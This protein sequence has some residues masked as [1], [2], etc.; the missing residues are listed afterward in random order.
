MGGDAHLAAQVHK[1]DDVESLKNLWECVQW[2]KQSTGCENLWEYVQWNEQ[3]TG[4]DD[5]LAGQLYK[6]DDLWTQ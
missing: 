3:S 1:Q 5:E 2:N 4:C 6:Q